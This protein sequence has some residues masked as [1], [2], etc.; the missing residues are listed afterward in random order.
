MCF[1][2][3]KISYRRDRPCIFDVDFVESYATSVQ[4]IVYQY[5]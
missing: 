5:G 1:L 3:Y 2:K 4:R